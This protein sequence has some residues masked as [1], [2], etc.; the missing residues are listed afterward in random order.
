MIFPVC[1]KFGDLADHFVNKKKKEKKP[2]QGLQ[3]PAMDR[4]EVS[5]SVHLK[6][7]VHIEHS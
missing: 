2:S 3:E 7:V 1:A 5:K 6:F 4:Q